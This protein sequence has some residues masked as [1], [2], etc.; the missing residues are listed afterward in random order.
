VIRRPIRV[1]LDSLRLLDAI[2][3]GGSFA[4]AARELFVV[5]SSITHAVRQLEAALGLTLFDRSGRRALLTIDGR[6]VLERGRRLLEQSAVFDSEVQRIATGWEPRL[7]LCV[8]QLL[9]MEPLAP[10][11]A[12]F[13]SAA[14]QTS[15]QI[16]REAAAGT[17]DALLSGRADLVVGAPAHGPPGGG[18]RTAP[19]R[20][21]RFVLVAAPDHTLAGI[22]G[23][24]SD[25]EL[26]RHRAVL[27][28]DT[29]RT[30][31]LLQY[32]LLRNPLTLHVP[33]T[34]S[35]VQALLLG[36]GCGFLPERVARPYVR[37][38]R[39]K[40]LQVRT[41]HPPSQSVLAWR[42]GQNGRALTWWIERLKR[43]QLARSLG[44]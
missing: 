6:Q 41:P 16:K 14:P 42:S 35:K 29:T 22:A 40:M 34:E 18:Y 4:A 43:P 19:L 11:V 1:S 27:V 21:T 13:C 39:L 15:L 28:G 30:L 20:E 33:D 32:G 9:R 5:T 31:P 37:A 36:L 25:E 2:E 10:I 7:V 26:S 12:A 44:S 17:W 24:V 8:D 23:L 3:R 38:G